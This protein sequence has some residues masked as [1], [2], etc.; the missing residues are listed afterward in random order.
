IPRQAF[1]A[2]RT[3]SPTLPHLHPALQ[4]VDP[5]CLESGEA[6]D[7]FTASTSR[8]TSSRRT[9]SRGPKRFFCNVCV[10]T[11]RIVPSHDANPSVFHSTI[12][13]TLHGLF[14]LRV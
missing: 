3:A 6:P 13:S 4:M 7:L 9:F 10:I 1:R 2:C 12:F 11:G 5:T 14:R 8:R